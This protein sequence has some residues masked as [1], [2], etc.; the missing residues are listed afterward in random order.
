MSR[1]LHI[2]ILAAGAGT[3]MKSRV[4]K[5]LQTVGGSALIIHVLD[6]VLQLEPAGIHV[7]FNPAIPQLQE[8]CRDYDI[9]WAAQAEQLGTGHAVLQAMPGIPDDAD[10][11]VLYG[12]IPLLEVP[13]LNMLIG[14]DPAGMKVLTMNV[15]DPGGYGRIVRDESGSVAGIV[16]ERDANESQRAIREVNSG[17]ILALHSTLSSCL[18]ELASDNSQN[19]YYLTDVIAIANSKGIRTSGVVAPGCPIIARLTWTPPTYREIVLA[20]TA[21]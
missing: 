13:V 16:E 4:P 19:E 21:Y 7:V 3:R 15:S 5:V 11:L 14:S 6:T 17:I 9:T 20:D 18:A 1:P 8:A 2:I 12:D 10:V